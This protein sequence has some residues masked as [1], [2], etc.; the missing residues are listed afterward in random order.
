[1]AQL[2]S[3]TSQLA[4]SPALA[5][6]QVAVL[7]E[8][9]GQLPYPL[10]EGAARQ[11]DRGPVPAL[12]APL[13]ERRC[14]Q[15]RVGVLDEPQQLI[16][17]LAVALREQRLGGG[18]EAVPAAGPARALA[19]VAVGDQAGVAERTQLLADRAD[20]DAEVGGQLVGGR[21]APAPSAGSSTARR[22]A[23]HPGQG[24]SLPGR[25][26]RAPARPAPTA[27]RPAGGG[28]PDMAFTAGPGGCRRTRARGTAPPAPPRRTPPPGPAR[29]PPPAGPGARRPARAS[30]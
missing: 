16:G 17:Q 1:M 3:V 25:L 28:L 13:L 15:R 6:G 4:P 22:P 14:H 11:A 2:R 10:V 21:L 19:L 18:G 5:V 7:V 20:G 9:A 26:R 30:R 12:L 8:D 24:D 23:G 29:R 27:G